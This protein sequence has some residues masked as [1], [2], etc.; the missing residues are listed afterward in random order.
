MKY[1]LLAAFFFL[2]AAGQLIQY[3]VGSFVGLFKPEGVIIPW[4]VA[5][6]FGLLA[7][8][9]G[10]LAVVYAI[11]AIGQALFGFAEQA[12]SKI[13]V[14]VHNGNGKKR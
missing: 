5:P 12:W 13:S 4:T 3:G 14:H 10:A 8:A 1:G 6:L 7:F 11:V 2:I 9:L